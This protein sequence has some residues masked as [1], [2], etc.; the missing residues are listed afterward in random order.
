ML[1]S[2]FLPISGANSVSKLPIED[3]NEG[4][5]LW[6]LNGVTNPKLATER[7]KGTLEDSAAD[8]LQ[9]ARNAR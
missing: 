6:D 2:T 3:R 9:I 4:A 5:W 7:S 1:S 8:T